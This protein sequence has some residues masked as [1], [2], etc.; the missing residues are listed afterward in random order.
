MEPYYFT[1]L[2]KL[3][4]TAYQAMKTGLTDLAPSFPVPKL[5]NKELADI[6]FELRLD[7]P[8]IFY[9]VGFK[10]RFYKESDHMEMIP[11][12]LFNKAKIK[13]HQKALAA[14]VTKL[15]RPAQTMSELEKEQYIHDFICTNVV[16]DKLKK[17]YSH[18]IIGPL[19]HGVGV[20]EGIAKSVKILCD[21]LGIWCVIAI[22][23]ANKEKGIQYRHAW[24]VVKVGGQYYHLDV[25][26]DNSLGHGD[27]IRYDYFNLSDKQ[28][29][30]DHQPVI[31]QVPACYESQNNYYSINKLVFT[32][33]EQVEKRAL[34][35]MRKKQRLIFLWKGSYLTREVLNE[36]VTLLGQTASQK[37]KHIKVSLNWSQAVLAVDFVELELAEELSIEEANEGERRKYNEHD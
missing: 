27:G 20:C 1:Q 18:E 3:H 26:F 14:R 17:Q 22:S 15:I 2:D 7:C 37:G 24:N 33:M 32:K 29:F 23:E 36:I 21:S 16:Y 10:Y 4:K 12:Y 30:R 13:E 25:T 11:E 9:V 31:Y 34:W 35:A 19:G 8:E 6:F 5:E 28:F